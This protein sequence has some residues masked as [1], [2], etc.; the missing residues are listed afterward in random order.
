G[1]L[2]GVLGGVI[3]GMAALSVLQPDILLTPQAHSFWAAMAGMLC[4]STLVFLV[5]VVGSKVFRKPAM[6]FGD[7]K[8]MGLLGAFTGWTGIVAG[9]FIACFVG[10]VVGIYLLLRYGSRY[11][12]FGPFLALGSLSMILWPEV[13]QRLLAWY[14]S[15]F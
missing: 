10:S 9:F 15:L 13:F 1:Y 14:M 3:G 4:G 2:G 12:P 7:V 8:L 5:G 11:V 6:G